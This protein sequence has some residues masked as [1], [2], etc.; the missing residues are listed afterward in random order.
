[1]ATVG[2]ISGLLQAVNRVV[3]LAAADEDCARLAVTSDRCV[4]AGKPGTVMLSLRSLT[5]S[6]SLTSAA[7]M[8]ATA[9]I[10]CV[11]SNTPTVDWRGA[12]T[13]YDSS[14]GLTFYDGEK[15]W[16]C[17]KNP[18]EGFGYPVAIP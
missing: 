5:T 17:G 6:A 18:P 1:L 10:Y 9:I 12:Q 11:A 13:G 2:A 14:A 15:G 4:L 8:Y 3:V 16:L 7:S